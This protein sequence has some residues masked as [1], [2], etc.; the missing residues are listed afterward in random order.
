MTGKKV[1]KESDLLQSWTSDPATLASRISLFYGCDRAEQRTP[2]EGV[3]RSGVTG[4]KVSPEQVRLM[5]VFI[6][7][8][9]AWFDATAIELETAIPG[10][11]IRHLLFTFFKMHLL[12]RLEV[13]GGYRYRLSPTAQA[14][15]YFERVQEAA[16]VMQPRNPSKLSSKP[17]AASEQTG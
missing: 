14:Q 3:R 1:S 17:A 6:A 9:E 8:P 5:A 12:E 11:S 4:K 2:S 10:S 16:E 15:P 13:H 7:E